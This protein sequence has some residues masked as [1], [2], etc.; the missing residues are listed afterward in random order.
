MIKIGPYTLVEVCWQRMDLRL[1]AHPAT[2]TIVYGTISNI[3]AGKND[4][5]N[6]SYVNM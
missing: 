1:C 6:A 3:G 2:T 5:E 4:V